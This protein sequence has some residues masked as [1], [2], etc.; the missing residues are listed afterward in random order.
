L[1]YRSPRSDDHKHRLE[2]L[3]YFPAYATIKGLT[4]RLRDPLDDDRD[5]ALAEAIA[6]QR[7][8]GNVGLGNDPYANAARINDGNTTHLI[9][10][11]ELLDIAQIVLRATAARAVSHQIS[12]LRVSTLPLRESR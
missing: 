4:V 9:V 12:H 2:G 6:V 1:V 3:F 7:P 11:H 8:T 10:S 5:L